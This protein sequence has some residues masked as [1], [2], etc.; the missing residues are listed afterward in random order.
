MGSAPSAKL[1]LQL[2]P[3]AA[4]L[5]SYHWLEEGSAS[6]QH[7][8]GGRDGLRTEIKGHK[9]HMASVFL[10]VDRLPA[11]PS[12]GLVCGP[13]LQAL[14]CPDTSAPQRKQRVQ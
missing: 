12:T 8:L 4:M 9:R 11:K 6:H 13:G 3:R 1:D 7:V 5:T 10:S 14:L 2:C